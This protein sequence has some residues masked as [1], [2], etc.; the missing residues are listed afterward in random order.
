MAE[1]LFPLKDRREI[2]EGTTAFWFDSS[3]SDFTFRAEQNADFILVN[4]P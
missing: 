4:P 1:H 2:V 3:G